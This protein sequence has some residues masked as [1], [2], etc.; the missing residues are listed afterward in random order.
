MQMSAEPLVVEV[1]AEALDAASLER[2]RGFSVPFVVFHDDKQAQPPQEQEQ[3]QQPQQQPHVVRFVRRSQQQAI[4]SNMEI[5]QLQVLVYRKLDSAS[6]EFIG[7]V[8]FRCW[9]TV[10][11]WSTD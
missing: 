3:Q 6:F 4:L 10:V 8:F 9:L 1:S 7:F 5:S 11:G 2:L